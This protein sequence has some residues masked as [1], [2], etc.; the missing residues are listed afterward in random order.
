[1]SEPGRRGTTRLTQCL[2][3]ALVALLALTLT[4]G[5]L[6]T[7]YAAPDPTSGPPRRDP[8]PVEVTFT[9]IGPRLLAGDAPIQVSAR[10]TNTG[11]DPISDLW[12][13]MQRDDRIS[14]RAGLN[15]VDHKQPSYTSVVGGELDLDFTL[16]PGQTRTVQLSAAPADLGISGPGS[17]P[18]LLNVQGSIDGE[19]GRVGQV[20]FTL[21]SADPA[22]NDTVSVTWVLPLIDRPHR[23]GE[24]DVFVDDALAGLVA[25]DGR[26]DRI[27]TA[28]ETHADASALTLLTDPGLIDEL[29]AMSDGYQVRTGSGLQGG[30]G[31]DDAAG[32]LER[33]RSL[34]ESTPIAI[35][36]YAD[37]DTVA[38]V[39]AGM[40]SVVQEALA[41]GETVVA[42]QL[43][44]TPY[45]QLAWPVDG[46]LT[47]AALDVLR[48][49]GITEVL[50]GGVAFGQEDYLA[51]D[52]DI[53]E[54]AATVLP[55]ATAIVADPALTRLLGDGTGFAGGAP[56]A[57]QR[58]AA[59]LATIAAEAPGRQRNVVLA[60]P[61]HWNPSS[62]LL[63][64]LLTL[65]T[66][67][68]WIA[69]TSLVDAASQ[70]AQDRG[71]L[72]YPA[73]LSTRELPAQTLQGLQVPISQVAEL[74]AAFDPADA[75]EV[76]APARAAVFRAV[77]SAWRDADG[78][79]RGP[80]ADA[81]IAAVEHIREQIR[82]VTPTNATYTLSA[83][84]APLVLTVENNLPVP[85]SY[86]I[87]LDPRQSAGLRPSDI[88]VQTI[89][90]LSRATV[91]VPTTVERSGTF[92]VVAQIKTP[93]GKPLGRDVTIM[94]SSSVYGTVALIVT[95]AAF[96]LLLA[97]I[98]RRWW[99]RR[100]FWAA[101]TDDQHDPS[102][103]DHDP[104]AGGEDDDW[105]LS[106]DDTPD[107][108]HS[109]ADTPDRDHSTDAG[110][111]GDR[112]R[113]DGP[114][115]DRSRE[116]G[117][118]AD[119]SRDDGE[120]AQHRPQMGEYLRGGPPDVV[121]PPSVGSTGPPQPDPTSL[122]EEDRP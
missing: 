73:D 82:I 105:D 24:A 21:P 80:G 85:V 33:L 66:T 19:P 52:D 84:D 110:S 72:D 11:E 121:N 18:I 89:P 30:S 63:D 91:Q 67:S 77:S 51:S 120:P 10:L 79:V 23:A 6:P 69:P 64:S 43:Q 45:T 86:R 36:P 71:P 42:Q 17:Y 100:Q 28:A 93:D 78:A 119:R 97:L 103:A 99:R 115:T 13:R 108:D 109:T 49:G 50:L 31:A 60:P 2:L 111:D 102:P 83:S 47:D 16:A 15:T 41:Y 94:V 113:E 8:F 22:Q 106:V 26:L 37:V 25:P 116:E 1:M 46:I 35:T 122:T 81:A 59:E 104:F 7:S 55:G 76:L 54:D 95:G 114:D 44:T 38:L 96:A 74:S 29:S 65:T 27:L 34:A 32:F 53:T 62:D 112:S 20:A 3:A 61:R 5:L 68:P 75:D 118:D 92:S 9:S 87:G 98:A 4:P 48:Q 39:R 90:A 58:V 56:A 57:T 117:P 88:G 40:G 14:S 107:R 101:Q 12:V 70:P